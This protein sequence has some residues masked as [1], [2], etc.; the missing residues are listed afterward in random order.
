MKRFLPKEPAAKPFFFPKLPQLKESFDQSAKMK[1]KTPQ[2]FLPLLF[3]RQLFRKTSKPL[4]PQF[5]SFLKTAASAKKKFFPLTSARPRFLIKTPLFPRKSRKL[6]KKNF[7]FPMFPRKAELKF[8]PFLHSARIS[9]A[10]PPRSAPPR[11][12][13]SAEE[14]KLPAALSKQ[15][16]ALTKCR[17]IM[18]A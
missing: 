17:W 14:R 15:E 2:N 1:R 12:T 13:P 3:P 7:A 16:P 8:L 11:K 18:T 4:K 5:P 9:S 10:A 6:K